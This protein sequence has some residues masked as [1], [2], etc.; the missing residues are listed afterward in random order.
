M[1]DVTGSRCDEVEPSK[2]APKSTDAVPVTSSPEACEH[3]VQHAW[4]FRRRRRR[5]NL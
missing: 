5:Q 1:I 2:E 3:L 4:V